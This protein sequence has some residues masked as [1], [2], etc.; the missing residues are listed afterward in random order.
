MTDLFNEY[1]TL[2]SDKERIKYLDSIFNSYIPNSDYDKF[3]IP[4]CNTTDSARIAEKIQEFYIKNNEKLISHCIRKYYPTYTGY[5]NELIQAG[6]MGI[7]KALGK[8]DAESPTKLATFFSCWIKGEITHFISSEIHKQTAHYASAIV[9]INKAREVLKEKGNF[10][11]SLRD[12]SLETG[13]RAVTIYNAINSEN[14]NNGISLTELVNEKDRYSNPIS[15]EEQVEA[16]SEMSI[17][18]KAISN[19]PEMQANILVMSYGLFGHPQKSDNDIAGY[20]KTTPFIIRKNKTEAIHQ[21]RYDDVMINE[22]SD[23]IVRNRDLECEV[24]CNMPLDAVLDEMNCIISAEISDLG[25]EISE[26][27]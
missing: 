8:Y 14:V 12:L 7:F 21:L 11:P 5:Y 27:C 22:F 10:N 17:L 18:K 9:K 25:Y 6:R 1:F 2:S 20:Y 24:I 26:V 16:E 13:V 19:L 23:R 15:T 4:L 3:L